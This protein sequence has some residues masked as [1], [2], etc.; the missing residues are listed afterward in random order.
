MEVREISKFA[1][2]TFK[3]QLWMFW[4]LE[5]CTVPPL[6]GAGE[7]FC[8]ALPLFLPWLFFLPPAALTERSRTSLALKKA[9]RNGCLD[10]GPFLP[11]MPADFMLM[12]LPENQTDACIRLQT[13]TLG[14]QPWLRH[15]N[16]VLGGKITTTMY[17]SFYGPHRY[18]SNCLHVKQRGRGL[19]TDPKTL[20]T[21]WHRVPI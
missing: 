14:K 4:I 3:E 13:S 20:T 10:W 21:S 7:D 9:T 11:M 6:L 18:C 12:L 1:Y 17:D 2:S 8:C 15:E 19:K 16:L 5:N